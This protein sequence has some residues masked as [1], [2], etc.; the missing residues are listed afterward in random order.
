MVPLPPGSQKSGTG[1]IR[2]GELFKV[3]SIFKKVSKALEP[4]K[5]VK[6]E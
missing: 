2:K 6:S 3:F 1:T 4:T 5:K